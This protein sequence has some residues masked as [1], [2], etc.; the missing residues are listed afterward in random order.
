[1]PTAILVDGG[2]FLRRINWK[3][4]DI[5]PDKPENIATAV[6]TLAYFH[7]A[8]RIGA[9]NMAARIST[10]NITPVETDELYRIFFYDCPPLTKKFICRSAK[11]RW[12]F[13]K[14]Q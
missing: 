9:K 11:R 12:I 10:N 7:M 4:P 5:D 8:L 2:F 1:M 6:S 13:R 14:H 3:F